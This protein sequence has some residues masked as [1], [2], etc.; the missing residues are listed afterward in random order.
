MSKWSPEGLETLCG[1][2]EATDSEAFYKAHVEDIDGLTD[3]ISDYI[4]LCVDNSIS[5]KKV[6]CYPNNKPRVTSE[7][8]TLLRKKKRAF[9]SGDKT[10][11]KSG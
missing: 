11:L 7:L 2:L 8:K 9:K 5:P 10:E 6:R 1:A 3:C 4:G